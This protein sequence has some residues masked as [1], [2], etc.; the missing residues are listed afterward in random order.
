MELFK[1][2]LGIKQIGIKDD[3]FE[4]GG[5]SLKGI[6]LVSKYKA[7]TIQDLYNYPTIEEIMKYVH[8]RKQVDSGCIVP[9]KENKNRCIQTYMSISHKK[10]C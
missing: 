2:I 8:T 10:K 4:L 9:L 7:I 1:E 5:T 6:Q 3:F